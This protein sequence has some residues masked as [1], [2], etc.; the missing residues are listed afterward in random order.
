VTWSHAAEDFAP[1]GSLRDIYVRHVSADDWESLY[2][3][4]IG[5]YPNVFTRDGIQIDPPPSVEFI[6][7]DRAVAFNRLML[8]VGG[9]RVNCHF[10]QSDDLELDLRPEEVVNEDR[11]A[12]L[13]SLMEGLGRLVNKN[14]VLTYQNGKD[15]AVFLEFRPEDGGLT[16]HKPKWR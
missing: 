7:Q 13:T 8:D 16:Y 14:V 5:T 10:F 3:W 4:L 12:A 6:W 2:R 9:L 15:D 11:F 1:D